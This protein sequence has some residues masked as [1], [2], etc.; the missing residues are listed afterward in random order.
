MEKSNS[1]L[2]STK[3]RIKKNTRKRNVEGNTISCGK[4]SS[5]YRGVTRHRW[6]GRYE[7]HLWDKNSWNL[8]QNKKGRQGLFGAYDEEETAAHAYDLAAIKYWGPDTVL[9]FPASSYLKDFEE[10]QSMPKEEYLA[11]LRRRSNG[12]SRGVSKYRGVARHH[13]NGRWEA[14]IG[15]IHGNKYLYLGTFSTQEE[16]A[17]AYDI[18]ALEYRGPHAVTNFNISCYTNL[19]P[20]FPTIHP[21]E[22]SNTNS[23]PSLLNSPH[24]NL[25]DNIDIQLP[26]QDFTEFLC[27]DLKFDSPQQTNLEETNFLHDLFDCVGFEENIEHLFEEIDSDNGNVGNIDVDVGNVLVEENGSYS[28]LNSA[29]STYP[30]PVSICS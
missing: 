9:N 10:M 1:H 20:T 13:H 27:S 21:K 29:S 15:R 11:T 23:T 28:T 24:E 14:R 17:Q 22:F 6:T 8:M 18:A 12:F 3:S 16:A 2:S 4:R 30:S 26:Q 19:P 5:V 25:S 7:A